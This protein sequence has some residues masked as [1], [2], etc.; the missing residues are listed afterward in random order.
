[1]YSV[2]W[3]RSR[4]RRFHRLLKVSSGKVRRIALWRSSRTSFL[5]LKPTTGNWRKPTEKLSRK[6]IECIRLALLLILLFLL[7]L[8]FLVPYLLSCLQLVQYGFIWRFQQVKRCVASG[9]ETCHR[10]CHQ[11]VWVTFRDVTARSLVPRNVGGQI[12]N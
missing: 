6:R 5:G 4:S 1:M 9:N 3:L 11:F 7:V 8:F 2:S 10:V 12:R